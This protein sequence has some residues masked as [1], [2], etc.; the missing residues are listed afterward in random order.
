M[1]LNELQE[2]LKSNFFE[3]HVSIRTLVDKL[4][5]DG[6]GFSELLEVE[7]ESREGSIVYVDLDVNNIPYALRDSQEF[8]DKWL[9]RLKAIPEL[10]GRK[11]I[12]VLLKNM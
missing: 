2:Q 6:W 3:E 8:K 5:K 9:P 10:K 12:A 7:F 1:E 4:G 11:E